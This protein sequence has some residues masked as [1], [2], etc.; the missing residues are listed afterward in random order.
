MHKLENKLKVGLGPDILYREGKLLERFG[1]Q[2]RRIDRAAAC[3]NL[4]LQLRDAA[5]FRGDIVMLIP[6]TH[7]PE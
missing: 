4:T 7:V 2:K 6:Q 3:Y 1:G 5:G